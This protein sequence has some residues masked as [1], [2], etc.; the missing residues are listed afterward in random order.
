MRVHTSE[1]SEFSPA[2]RWA[3]VRDGHAVVV[4][5]IIC[6]LDTVSGPRLR[7]DALLCGDHLGVAHEDAVAIEQSA[8]WVLGAISVPPRQLCIAG[9]D[10]VRLYVGKARTHVRELN[11]PRTDCLTFGSRLVTTPERTAADIARYSSDDDCAFADLTALA[12]RTGYRNRH[13]LAI[14]GRT[15][16]LPFAKRARQ[17]LGAALAHAVGVVDAVDAANGIEESIKVAGVAHFKNKP[18]ES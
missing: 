10:G 17:R 14:V 15:V 11:I 13:A 1:L 8:L 6:I 9:L 3:L 18:I 4:Q 16:H 5:G 12:Q 7:L 2:E